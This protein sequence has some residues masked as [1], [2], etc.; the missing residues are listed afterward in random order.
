MAEMAVYRKCGRLRIVKTKIKCSITD[1][2]GRAMPARVSIEDAN[3][4][5]HAPRGA[6]SYGINTPPEWPSDWGVKGR[7]EYFYTEGKFSLS[8]P[9]GPIRITASRGCEYVPFDKII[10]VSRQKENIAI[11]LTG[12]FD[13]SAKGWFCGDNHIHLTHLPVDYALR[14]KD[15]LFIAR[16]EGLHIAG[17][18]DPCFRGKDMSNGK[19]YIHFGVEL[20]H[21]PVLNLTKRLPGDLTWN[22]ERPVSWFALHDWV[23]KNGGTVI[24]GHPFPFNHLFSGLFT[25]DVQT[26]FMSHYELPLNVA[27]GK[28]DAFDK[29]NNRWSSL[30]IWL[31]IWY[32][33]L[34]CGFR[35]PLS[36][37][38]DACPSLKTTLPVGIYRLY[39]QSNGL[40]YGRWL[41]AVKKGRSFLT[42]G[43]LL[44]FEVNGLQPGGIVHLDGKK[45]RV[46]EVNCKA[47]SIYP[48]DS[49]ELVKNGEVIR[50]WHL[51][52]AKRFQGKCR[53]NIKT[54]C[55][56]ALRTYRERKGSSGRKELFAHTNPVHVYCGKEKIASPRDA[57]FFLEWIEY[58]FRF[59]IKKGGLDNN[60][61]RL[62]KKAQG[63]YLDQMPLSVKKAF[64]RR[65]SEIAGISLSDFRETGPNCIVNPGFNGHEPGNCWKVSGGGRI[66]IDVKRDTK[67]SF[68]I[69]RRRDEKYTFTMCYQKV[70]VTPRT[71]YVLRGE[72]RRKTGADAGAMGGYVS[73]R[74]VALDQA[75]NFLGQADDRTAGGAWEE[76]SALLYVEKGIKMITI[77]CVL[78]ADGTAGF[79]N[80][81]MKRC[82]G[83]FLDLLC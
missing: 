20:G 44:F 78:E 54:S 41:E 47:L 71:Y 32:G 61:V 58:C 68:W 13:M 65:K 4:D 22:F 9:A 83:P 53:I 38:T 46:V 80:I 6:L 1:E 64:F 73:A 24:M 59:R 67:R 18:L 10:T 15:G 42:D 12:F 23:H 72:I 45:K 8:V 66:F 3:G 52:H 60:T 55:W 26:A 5:Y 35:I 16:A 57:R 33:L 14:P 31:R 25:G 63:R 70:N 7:K 48:M 79:R 19:C 81:R 34:N 40:D 39:A 51:N 74:I 76:C 27:L 36:A 82:E 62:L 30:R 49:V 69:Q 21:H 37:G 77:A 43:P 56:L 17:Y 29:E 50:K 11:T 28:V 2:A 75:G